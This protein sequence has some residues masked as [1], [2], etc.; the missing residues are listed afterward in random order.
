[1]TCFLR[2]RREA[3]ETLVELLVTIVIMGASFV[4]ILAG[5]GIAIASSDSHR[6]EASAEGI[7]RSYG[8]RIDDPRDV[9]Y[10]DCATTAT[11]TN[12]VG[13]TAPAGWT[14]SVTGVAYLQADNTYSSSCPS[15]ERGAQQLTLRAVSPHAK[16]AATETVVVVKRKP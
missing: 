14:L 6:Q 13:F 3:G 11:Y 16:H 9:P 1:V 8:E 10:V 4:A 5:V 15:P 7:L 2:A 12:P